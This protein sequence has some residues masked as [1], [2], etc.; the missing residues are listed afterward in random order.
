MGKPAKR[1]E[2]EAGFQLPGP[3][4]PTDSSFT[5]WFHSMN[6][7]Q[8]LVI[9]GELHPT[10]F[11]FIDMFF[12]CSFKLSDF[13]SHDGAIFLSHPLACTSYTSI[14]VLIAKTLKASEFSQRR[15]CSFHIPSMTENN[16]SPIKN[17]HLF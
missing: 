2:E 16:P 13:S 17:N 12:I 10:C 11:V 6:N 8:F 7:A 14:F 3:R 9:P 15:D 4:L 1:I 5:P